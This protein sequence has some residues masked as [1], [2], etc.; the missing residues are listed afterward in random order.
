M[1]LH[2]G[3]R[4]T[5]EMVMLELNQRTP[6]LLGQNKSL[7][8]PISNSTEK[9]EIDLILR[10]LFMLKQDTELI[11]KILIHLQNFWEKN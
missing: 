10:Q 4:I 1:V 11:Q 2:K 6:A 7:P 8:I 3:E 9:V 5:D